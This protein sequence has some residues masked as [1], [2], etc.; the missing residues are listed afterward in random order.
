M[1]ALNDEA[2][3]L[4][5]IKPWDW[6]CFDRNSGGLSP[7]WRLLSEA[8]NR[9]AM[10]GHTDPAGAVLSLLATGQ[11]V[12]MGNY[13][14][15]AYRNGHFRREGMA[16]IPSRRWTVLKE[17]QDA[18]RGFGPFEVTLTHINGDW[19]ERKEARGNWEWQHNR[20]S[21][22]QSSGGDFLDKDF[23][24]ETYSAFGIEIR[25]ADEKDHGA[26]QTAPGTPVVERNRGGAPAKYDWERAVAAIVFQWADE[27]SWQPAMQADV[28]N[29]L[30]DWFAER[31]EHPSDSLLKERARWLF[32][33]IQ[34][35][36]GE[37][38]NL[39][40]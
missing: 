22:A 38:N 10:E 4:A 33:E 32:E 29:R 8:I 7:R 31:G 20:F 26:E 12:A 21:T 34:R 1:N 28:K 14:W 30:A 11:L 17:E 39:A 2:A 9:L 37:A 13:Q 5:I 25:P 6:L 18:H 16:N 24:E 35:R 23:F 19:R 27:G 40:A 3:A 36:D 15:E